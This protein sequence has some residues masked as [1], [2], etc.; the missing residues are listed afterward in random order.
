MSVLLIAV[1]IGVLDSSL[2]EI[3][4]IPFFVVV[5]QISLFDMIERIESLIVSLGW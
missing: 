1:Y 4:P 3:L 2:I 5:R